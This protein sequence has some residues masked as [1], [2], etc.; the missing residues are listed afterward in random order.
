MSMFK[1]LITFGAS[2]RVERVQE[3][4]DREAREVMAFQAQVQRSAQVLEHKAEDLMYFKTQALGQLRSMK[5][6]ADNFSVRDREL[7]LELPNAS[8]AHKQLDHVHHTLQVG[9]M[10]MGTL[11]GGTTGLSTAA[12][13]W[14]LAGYMGTASTGTAISTLSGAA[15]TNATLAW[16][17]GGAVAAGGG[18]MAAGTLVLGGLVAVPALGIAALVSHKKANERIEHLERERKQ[19]VRVERE[20]SEAQVAIEFA[21]GRC[22]ELVHA[23]SRASDVFAEEYQRT[24]QRVHRY[25][26]LSKAYRWCRQK[27]T[28]SYYDRAD[29]EEIASL[30][31][32]CAELAHLIDQPLIPAKGRR[33]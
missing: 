24:H 3:Q 27:I 26:V 30:V 14:M 29:L 1:N 7:F 22:D 20:L 28:G 8:A 10:V 2:G 31:P 23:L 12:G 5:N 32:L 6:L 19:L 16:F 15:A 13:A 9:D 4:Y 33:A 21:T 18:G 17:G 11:K 25:G